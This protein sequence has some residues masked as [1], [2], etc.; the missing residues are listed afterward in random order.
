MQTFTA[1]QRRIFIGCFIAYTGAYIGRLNL[2]AALPQMMTGLSITQTQ[3]GLLQT[4]F[5]I[6]YAIGQLLNGALVD[7]L[8]ARRHIVIGLILSALCNLLLGMSHAYGQLLVLWAL[9]GAAQSMLWT[10]IV[11][12]MAN[13]FEGKQ[14]IWVSFW[15]SMTLVLGHFLA[16]A[17]SGWIATQWSWRYSFLFS[18]VVLVCA[19]LASLW[20]LHDPAHARQATDTSAAPAYVMPM[21][22]LLFKTGLIPVLVFCIASG[23]VRDGIMTWAP[24]I[25]AGLYTG[26]TL[27]PV[28]FSLL[29]PVVNLL[30][31]L[32]G[33]FFTQRLR[34]SVRGVIALLMMLGAGCAFLLVPV[35]GMLLT[36]LLLGACCACMFGVNPLTTTILPME[37][38]DV[39]R[40][41]LVA[42][43]VD[44]LIYVGSALVG[45]T[46]GSVQQAYGLPAVYAL[47]GIV[48]LLG[49]ASILY[50]AHARR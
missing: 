26:G 12:L 4:A 48:A 34:G 38:A 30:G 9:N 39:G 43:M 28:L 42:G 1:Q 33:R 19:A 18:G 25:L 20:L 47:W 49:V 2:A 5:A 44:S 23:F 17:L 36:A 37:Y 29:I 14:R 22:T 40:V 6:I 11:K 41:G 32:L 46:T 15:I 27:S 50:S 10:P 24:T 35:G 13:W 16:W 21:R 31:L 7:R 8:S 45:V 3:G